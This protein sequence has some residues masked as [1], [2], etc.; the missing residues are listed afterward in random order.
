[1]RIVLGKDEKVIIGN[2]NSEGES[3]LT[4]ANINGR[5]LPYIEGE[6]VPDI[7]ESTDYL[8]F[9]HRHRK[10]EGS[11]FLDSDH[12]VVDRKDWELVRSSWKID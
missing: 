11:I 3:D 1:M 12:V 5:L 2:K 7:L 10:M 6:V 9:L 4:V 8:G